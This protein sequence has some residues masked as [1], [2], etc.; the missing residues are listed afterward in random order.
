MTRRRAITIRGSIRRRVGDSSSTSTER[1]ESG[2]A[3]RWRRD[4]SLR[5]GWRRGYCSLR[6]RRRR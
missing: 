4:C 1:D 6:R 2:A 3:C 5:S